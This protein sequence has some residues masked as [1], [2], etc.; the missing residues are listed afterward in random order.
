MAR[1]IKHE[2][3]LNH[4]AWAI[5]YAD[6]ITLL[7]AFFVVMYSISAVN[8]GKYRV[9]SDALSQAFAGP[10]KSLKP[11]QFGSHRQSGTNS[12]QAINI[13]ETNAVEQTVAGD[14]HNL[15]PAVVLPGKEHALSRQQ[16]NPSGNTGYAEAKERAALQHM[17][18]AVA[19]A[20]GPLISRNMITVHKSELKLE[21]E[22]RTD[23]LFAS[24][25]ALVDEKARPVLAE[26]AKILKPFPN[27]LLID[28][29]TD[30]VPIHTSIFA[31]NWELS[32]ARAASVV[33]LFMDKGID[34]LRMSVEGFGEY[35]P[36]ADNSTV[37]GRNH[38]RRVVL[39]VL[40]NPGQPV[41]VENTDGKGELIHTS[42]EAAPA[43]DAAS[44]QAAPAAA[45]A[46]AAGASP[47]A[48]AAAAADTLGAAA[49]GAPATAPAPAAAPPGPAEAAVPTAPA[50]ATTAPPVSSTS[51]ASAAPA[52][53][54]QPV[55]A[56]SVAVPAAKP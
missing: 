38:N 33:H 22:I 49:A 16:Y 14:M 26:L 36:A 8:E 15:R 39:V 4:E 51:P 42:M 29:H 50:T 44:A 12:D 54:P 41:P 52:A 47:N 20:M 1:K 19:K 53:A 17:A 55:A 34:P 46:P 28:G 13:I 56:A 10:P 37:E 24:G 7:L 45:A 21:I 30:N 23:I 11:V 5:P 2:D 48:T 40:A 18:D 25:S 3:H 43:A 32:S 6:M 31:S 9:L 27:S 35:R